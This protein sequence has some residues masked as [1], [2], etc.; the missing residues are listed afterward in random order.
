M[1]EGKKGS[2]RRERVILLRG[3]DGLLGC[4]V[5]KFFWCSPWH[6]C[7][8]HIRSRMDTANYGGVVLRFAS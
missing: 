5:P 8:K 7:R 1:G 6:R 4:V 2:C 3:S